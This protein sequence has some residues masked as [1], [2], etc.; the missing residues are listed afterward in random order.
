M[1]SVPLS[2]WNDVFSVIYPKVVAEICT[3][4]SWLM[5]CM[6]GLLCELALLFFCISGQCQMHLWSNVLPINHT[7][8]FWFEV[9]HFLI[10]KAWCFQ[11]IEW[12]SSKTKQTCAQRCKNRFWVSVCV[13]THVPEGM[14]A[15][16]CECI[17]ALCL[18]SFGLGTVTRHS[19]TGYAQTCA[20]E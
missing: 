14:S 11:R 4:W 7:H 2:V 20:C 13:S 5:Q 15:L 1:G 16:V 12:S 19:G 3:F 9:L 18:F 10:P 6:P 8:K 17:C